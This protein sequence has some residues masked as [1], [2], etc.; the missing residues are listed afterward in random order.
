[1]KPRKV[2]TAAQ[3]REIDRR[4]TELGIPSLILMENAAQRVV[5][6]L[7]ERYSPISE[8]RIVVFCGKGNNGGDALAVAR[9]LRTRFAP[10][11]LDVLLIAPPEQLSGDA[12]ANYRMWVA[13][14][15]SVQQSMQPA[16]QSASLIVDGILGS[17]VRGA[18]TGQ[19]LEWIR[20]INTGFPRAKVVAIDVPSGMPSDVN[21][22]ANEF[23]RADACVTFTAPRICHVLAPLSRHAGELRIAPIGTPEMLLDQDDRIDLAL[24]EPRAFADLLRARDPGGNKGDYGHVLVLAGSRSKTG[25]A[26]MAGLAAL[27]AGAGLATVA[28]AKSAIPTIA[29]H[30]PELMTEF[31]PETGSGG[32][33]SEAV[34]D[35]KKLIEKRDV[36]AMGP[37]L[38]T[39]DPTAAVVRTLWRECKKPMVVDADALNVLSTSEW[40]PPPQGSL[41]VLTPHPG[42]MARLVSSSVKDVQ[43]D[44]VNCA[45]RF[46]VERGVVLV[47]KGEC[48]LIAFPDG[49]VW[50]NPTG[51]P[52]MATG[53]T[54]DVLTGMVAGFLGQFP[55][56][57][58]LA[59]AG[60]VWLHGRAGQLGAEEIG[61]QAFVATD[62][63][64][65]LP[66]AIR[67]ARYD[68]NHH[69]IV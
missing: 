34:G 23:A 21:E 29:A 16:M 68:A 24:V 53:G 51:S 55:N 66:H 31:L 13:C 62:L 47:L 36:V 57:T 7:A 54:G 9:Q 15:G 5:E 30:S 46:S 38:G 63:L 39:E 45:R 69:D 25:A 60:A 33:A 32:V 50:I 12:A 59:V 3:M 44:R 52:S 58:D 26:A 6:Y 4:T 56:Q 43:H 10:Q 2:V 67:R 22:T 27:R 11:N 20:A 41:R 49:R 19:A 48:T 64:R 14:G 65:M 37:G 35:L 61:E 8:Q 42:E 18:A 17:G 28:S 1:M 40:V